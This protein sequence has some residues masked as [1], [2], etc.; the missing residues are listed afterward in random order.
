MP[1]WGDRAVKINNSA[2]PQHLDFGFNL[3]LCHACALPNGTF[4][5]DCGEII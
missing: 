1:E 3:L 5:A 2:F 4:E